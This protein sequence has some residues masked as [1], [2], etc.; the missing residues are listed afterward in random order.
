MISF[1]EDYI[2]FSCL[3]SAAMDDIFELDDETVGFG[4]IVIGIFFISVSLFGW[5]L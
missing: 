1:S 2:N 3:K 4:C 5:I